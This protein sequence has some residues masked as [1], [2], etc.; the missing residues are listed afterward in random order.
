MGTYA[1]RKGVSWKFDLILNLTQGERVGEQISR[2]QLGKKIST[3]S[4]AALLVL[5]CCRV[6]YEGNS[7]EKG[8]HRGDNGRGSVA[9]LAD[10]SPS[11]LH[12]TP[13][14]EPSKA[15]GFLMSALLCTFIYC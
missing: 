10:G 8:S 9:F 7:S 2:G 3:T 4:T 14:V 12:L 13:A 6:F 5:H 15:T 11:P 1:N